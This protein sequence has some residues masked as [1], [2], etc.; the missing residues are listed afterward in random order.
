MEREHEDSSTDA[1]LVRISDSTAVAAAAAGQLAV[2]AG[3]VTAANSVQMYQGM[4]AL[5]PVIRQEG[6]VALCRRAYDLPTLAAF[7]L[8][9]FSSEQLLA[10]GCLL[11]QS[12]AIVR[13]WHLLTPGQHPRNHRKILQEYGQSTCCSHCTL[14][15]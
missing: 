4:S 1:E 5:I 10:T 11:V 15:V 12:V 13:H 14:C 9:A 2:T 7:A 6:L 3:A 8:E